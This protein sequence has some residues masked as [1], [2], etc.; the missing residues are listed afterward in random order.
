MYVPTAV[1]NSP[2]VLPWVDTVVF[3]PKAHSPDIDAVI[4]QHRVDVHHPPRHHPVVRVVTTLSKATRRLHSNTECDTKH[5]HLR[6]LIPSTNTPKCTSPIL[7][8]KKMRMAIIQK[9]K[10]HHHINTDHEDTIII[11]LPSSLHSKSENSIWILILD[12]DP[13]PRPLDMSSNRL[14]PRNPPKWM[15]FGMSLMSIHRLLHSG[16]RCFHL[17]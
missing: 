14:N 15:P 6:N 11:P 17:I 10:T 9:M 1:D 3:T 12:Y 4:S 8:P 13:V 5:E 2:A 7:P 16:A